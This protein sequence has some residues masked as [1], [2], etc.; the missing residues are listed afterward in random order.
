MKFNVDEIREFEV[1]GKTYKYKKIDTEDELDWVDYYLEAKQNPQTGKVEFYQNLKK[2]ALC[3]FIN[4]VEVPDEE[5]IK[6]ISKEVMGY[7]K[8]WKNMNPK[9]K[10]EMAKKL[11][12]RFYDKLVEQMDKIDNEDNSEVKKN[13]SKQS[14]KP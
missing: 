10:M 13:S 8:E 7:E 4:I 6:K 9:E 1:E 14:P 11:D 2:R 12:P 5:K 3:K